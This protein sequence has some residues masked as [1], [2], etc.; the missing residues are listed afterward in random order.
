MRF[1]FFI[2]LLFT[3]SFLVSYAQVSDY[4]RNISRAFPVTDAISVEISNKY[5][6]VHIVPWDEDSVKF[7]IDFRIR[8]K[9][10]QKLEKMR[11]NIEFE[12]TN[13]KYFL[14]ARTKFGEGGSD[15]LKDL[16]DIAGSYLSSSNSVTINYTVHVPQKAT[17]KIENKFGDV[18]FEDHDG[19]ISLILSYGNI[20]A[21]RLNGRTDIKITSGDGE[22]TSIK[23]G[24][25][26]V[27]Y[28]NLHIREALKLTAQT[29][30]S[31]INIDKM[32]SL[33]INSRRDKLYINEIQ[34]LSGE[35]YFTDVNIG[36]LHNDFNLTGR[37][38]DVSIDDIRRTFST[39]NISSDLTDVT[40]VFDKPLNFS[41]D[42]THHQSVTLSYPAALGKL[43]TR[44]INQDDK[45]SSTTGVF[46]S[47]S[48]NSKVTIRAPRKSNLVIS[49]R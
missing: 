36:I 22:I 49:S 7:D 11:R 34:S 42:L 23:D 30:S 2:S 13:G 27:A 18:F 17:L 29:Q 21:N 16:V 28:S 4:A 38:G 46:G 43:N 15:I 5:G 37:Y 26:V 39:I 44:V 19:T 10:K 9:D 24:M 14:V 8:A 6:R 33:K 31:V 35:S 47:G 3:G 48:A 12:F 32:G 25:I 1:K 40:L 45:T 41:F 20:K